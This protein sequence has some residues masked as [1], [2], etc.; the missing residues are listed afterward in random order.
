MNSLIIVLE[1]HLEKNKFEPCFTLYIK[2][3]N[4]FRIR[5]PETENKPCTY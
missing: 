3:S 5:Y 4:K 2:I 1:Q